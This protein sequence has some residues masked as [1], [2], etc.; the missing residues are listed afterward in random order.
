LPCIYDTTWD[1]LM[2]ADDLAR[3]PAQMRDACTMQDDPWSRMAAAVDAEPAGSDDG[4]HGLARVA[5][6]ARA[7]LGQQLAALRAGAGYSQKGFAPLTGYGRSTLAMVETGR[8]NAPRAFWERAAQALSAPVL[9]AGYEQIE[10]MVATGRQIA[11]ERAQAE[12]DARV[13]AW[14][15]ARL[16]NGRNAHSGHAM[17]CAPLPAQPGPGEIHVWLVSPADIAHHLIIPL[18]QADPARI[19]MMVSKLINVTSVDDTS[20]ADQQAPSRHHDDDAGTPPGEFPGARAAMHAL[21]GGQ[22]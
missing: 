22:R 2:D 8:Q 20:S 1:Q 3:K 18:S 4:S 11:A 5:A 21:D 10:A 12:R 7:A 17:Q 6:K 19:A 14:D 15:H 13:R 9:V 16:V